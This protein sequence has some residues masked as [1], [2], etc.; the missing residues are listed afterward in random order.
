MD[1]TR[2]QTTEGKKRCCVDNRRRDG[3]NLF[4]LGKTCNIL[5]S[6]LEQR[7]SHLCKYLRKQCTHTQVM[8][9]IKIFNH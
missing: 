8:E 1:C 9:R 4:F 2:E 5:L 6:N 3:R 7:P